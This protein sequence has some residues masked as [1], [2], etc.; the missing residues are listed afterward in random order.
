MTTYRTDTPAG[1]DDPS[2]GDDRIREAKVAVQEI[3]DV[4]HYMEAS[5]ANV[6]DDAARGKHRQVTFKEAVAITSVLAGE[7][8]LF[9]KE[10]DGIPELHFCDDED[11]VVQLTTGGLTKLTSAALTG[12]LAYNAY[13]TCKD[14]GGTGTINLIRGT[15]GDKAQLP[16]GARLAS[17]AAP[18]SSYDIAN[19]GYVDATIKK[20]DSGWYAVAVN[21][22]YTKAH[23]LGA[24][25]TTVQVFYSDTSDGS[26]DVASVAHPFGAGG[27]DNASLCEMDATNI[28]VRT[29]NNVAYYRDASGAAKS[30]TSGY[31]K[32][33]ALLVAD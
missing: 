16:D 14:I 21:T 25:P 11:N 24:V 8:A 22:T 26:G 29:G 17:S 5:G 1:G 19:K 15:T 23:G 4:D 32:I 7:G 30:P 10:V 13:S 6:Y 2:E 9:V 3:L 33:V 27:S 28:K 18:I 31:H 20:Y 12:V